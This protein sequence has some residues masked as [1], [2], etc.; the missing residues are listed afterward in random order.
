MKKGLIAV[1]ILC[2]LLTVF[3]GCGMAKTYEAPWDPFCYTV[4]GSRVIRLRAAES[5]FIIDL[6]N[7]GNWT[8]GL[9]DCTCDFVFYTQRQTV[10][11]H[12]ECGTFND[13]TNRKSMTV[14]EAQ[15]LQISAF[16]FRAP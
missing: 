10:R 1:L 3:S 5:D 11:Y 8:D 4:E 7:E 6:L 15:R 16:L 2:A 14:P 12:S 9:S 13:V